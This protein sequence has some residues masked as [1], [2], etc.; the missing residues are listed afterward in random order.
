VKIQKV[1]GTDRTLSVRQQSKAEDP[2]GHGVRKA[3]KD[4][5]EAE[6]QMPPVSSQGKVSKT[7]HTRTTPFSDNK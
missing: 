1:Q 3:V 7:D 6:N 2:D 5:L 4:Q